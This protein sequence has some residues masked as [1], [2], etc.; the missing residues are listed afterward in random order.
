MN[1]TM[2]SDEALDRVV[3]GDAEPM[4]MPTVGPRL[5]MPCN[6][7]TSSENVQSAES[8]YRDADMAKEMTEYTK[9]NI[10]LQTAAAMIS[11]AE[12][13]AKGIL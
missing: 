7:T 11:E 8:T 12:K 13:V 3:G 9:N 2:L 6:L 5:D 10:L 4:A 1:K